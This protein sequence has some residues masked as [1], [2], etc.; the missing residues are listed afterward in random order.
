MLRRLLKVDYEA[1]AQALSDRV[2]H[3]IDP[4]VPGAELDFPTAREMLRT[5]LDWLLV[6]MHQPEEIETPGGE[7]DPILDILFAD[8]HHQVIADMTVVNVPGAVVRL[9]GKNLLMPLV[10]IEVFM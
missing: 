7:P 1:L 8:Q 10:K 3:P 6:E 2:E 4:D 5:K 9:H